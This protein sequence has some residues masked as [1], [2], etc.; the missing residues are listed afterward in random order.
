[1]TAALATT[2]AATAAQEAIWANYLQL[3][4]DADTSA[5]TCMDALTTSWDPSRRA[6]ILSTDPGLILLAPTGLSTIGG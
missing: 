2:N 5:Q 6:S 1:M 3:L 4:T